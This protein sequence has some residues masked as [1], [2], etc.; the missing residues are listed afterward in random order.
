MRLCKLFL[1]LGVVALVSTPVFAQGRGG[2]GRGGGSIGTLAQNKS[3]QEELKLDKDAV[4]KVDEALKKVNEDL[5]D[6]VAKIRDRNASQE[7]RA[8]ARKKVGEAQEKALKSALSEKQ[9]ARLVQIQL[10][11]RGLA[12]FEDEK[13]QKTLKLSDEQKTKIKEINDA[14]TKERSELFPQGQR[15]AADAVTKFQGLRKDAMSN[16]IKAL[17]DGQKKALKELTGE[18]FEVKF[19]RQGTGRGGRG[20]GGQKPRTDF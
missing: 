11:Q 8:A 15:P 2:F 1:A 13:V 7:D 5:K 3:V 12:I 4:T 20:N 9:F 16:A 14:L 19:D 6:D 17:D 10:Q 18:P